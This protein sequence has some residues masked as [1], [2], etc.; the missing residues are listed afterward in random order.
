MQSWHIFA[1][2]G[3]YKSSVQNNSVAKGRKF[4]PQNTRG[5]EKKCVGP[6]KSA[7]EFLADLSKKGQSSAENCNF[8]LTQLNFF[9][10]L[11]EHFLERLNFVANVQIC[12]LIW[13]K[14][15]AR[16][17]QHCMQNK[18]HEHYVL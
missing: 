12:W 13:P 4:R 7:A 16:S 9:E 3:I 8:I 15:F 14:D 6:G 5:D 10:S 11:D 18:Q 17:W 2:I 1:L